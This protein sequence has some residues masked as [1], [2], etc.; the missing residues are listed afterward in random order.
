MYPFETASTFIGGANYFLKFFCCYTTYLK[1][2]QEA[3]VSGTPINSRISW[4][5]GKLGILIP[6]DF[7]WARSGVLHECTRAG[8]SDMQSLLHILT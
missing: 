7:F 1:E 6:F 5:G 3:E 2:S 4:G 8:R